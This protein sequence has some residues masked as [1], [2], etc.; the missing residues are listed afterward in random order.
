MSSFTPVLV[1][2]SYWQKF[3]DTDCLQ[4]EQMLSNLKLNK[5]KGQVVT[6]VKERVY[7]FKINIKNSI[8]LDGLQTQEQN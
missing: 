8:S 3:V 6:I 2:L 4:V 5:K 7:I 1:L